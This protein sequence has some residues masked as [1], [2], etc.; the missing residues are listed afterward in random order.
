MTPARRVQFPK[1]YALATWLVAALALMRALVP[2]GYMLDRAPEDG[3][4]VMHMCSGSAMGRGADNMSAMAM[5]SGSSSED[6]SSGQ[7][8]HATKDFSCPFALSA[9][10]DLPVISAVAT[11]A[12]LSIPRHGDLAVAS[13]PLSWL[14][15]PPLPGRGPPVTI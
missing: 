14:S 5:P 9:I 10:A 1:A 7:S 8:E 6:D 11:P 12:A 2:A 3:Q 13:E 15:R 4:L